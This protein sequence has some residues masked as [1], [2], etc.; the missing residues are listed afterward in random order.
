MSTL[1]TTVRTD[2]WDDGGDP[3]DPRNKP[4][5]VRMNSG[6]GK[7]SVTDDDDDEENQGGGCQK[8]TILG[9]CRRNPITGEVLLGNASI[10]ADFAIVDLWERV[11]LFGNPA[12]LVEDPYIFKIVPMPYRTWMYHHYF[13][14]RQYLAKSGGSNGIMDRVLAENTVDDARIRAGRWSPSL[15]Y[16]PIA[17]ISCLTADMITV[18]FSILMCV[19]LIG[20]AML[21]NS[22]RWYGWVRLQTSP[23][24][25]VYFGLI[26]IRM[27]S[28]ASG[29][30]VFAYVLII[31]LML[32]DFSGDY[33]ALMASGSHAKYKVIRIL[34]S[35]VFVARRSGAA[36]LED[37]DWTPVS[38]LISGV[39]A[40]TRELALIAEIRGLVCQLKPMSVKDW[41]MACE[42][43]NSTG[44]PLSFMGL[45]LFNKHHRTVDEIELEKMLL[46]PEGSVHALIEKIDEVRDHHHQAQ[47]EAHHRASFL[48]SVAESKEDMADARR[49][50]RQSMSSS[51]LLT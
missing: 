26:V 32:A 47:D 8:C 31:L 17:F 46:Q 2:A 48:G 14:D 34:P 21:A 13:A 3:N 11:A 30:I 29:F 35:R 28:G 7:K 22:P 24:R 41:T 6:G 37:D 10:L 27:T 15:C 49:S 1:L 9:K 23:L 12:D 20:T 5:A 50:H 16:T 25:L 33:M 39:G 51:K 42:Q 40:W 4:V 45:D 44:R 19:G 43:R 36:F 38:E 18:Y